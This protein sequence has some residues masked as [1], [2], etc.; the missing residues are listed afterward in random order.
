MRKLI[1]KLSGYLP[2]FRKDYKKDLQ[3]IIEILKGIRQA[4]IQHTQM[5]SNLLKAVTNLQRERESGN[6]KSKDKK[7]DVAFG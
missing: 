6:K 5:E 1:K 2:I 7:D 3:C 4:D